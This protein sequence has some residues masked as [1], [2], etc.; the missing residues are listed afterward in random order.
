M[1]DRHLDQ[2]LMCAIYVTSKVTKDDRTFHDIMKCYRQQPQANSEVRKFY[3]LLPYNIL[4][5]LEWFNH[6]CGSIQY[7][8]SW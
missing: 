6:G 5:V 3:R 2:M 7:L 8:F 1:K 4:I